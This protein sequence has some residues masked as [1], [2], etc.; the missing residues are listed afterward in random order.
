MK[1]F[2]RRYFFDKA[3]RNW[4]TAWRMGLTPWDLAG[5]VSPPLIDALNYIRKQNLNEHFEWNACVPGCGTGYDC[6]YL[7]LQPEIKSV[8]GLDL[9]SIAITRAE[10][11][12]NGKVQPNKLYLICTNFFDWKGYIPHSI[13]NKS[14]K[15]N[16]V[17]DYLFFSAIEPSLRLKWANTIAT[18][19]HPNVGWLIT[20]IFPLATLESDSFKGPPYH[21][22]LMDYRSVLDPLGFELM[23]STENVPSIKPRKGREMLAI[24]KLKS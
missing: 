13:E 16:I 19:M 5:T 3:G 1:P 12:A 2:L 18:I 11:F 14:I 22:S 4:D 21:V 8:V 23:M 9:S 6:V 10:E 24:W 7:S 15:F 20:V 17:F